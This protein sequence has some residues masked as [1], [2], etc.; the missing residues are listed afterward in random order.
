MRWNSSSFVFKAKDK[1][2]R[3]NLLISFVLSNAPK[4]CGRVGWNSRKNTYANIADVSSF[5]AVRQGKADNKSQRLLRVECL[6]KRACSSDARMIRCVP[7]DFHL[8]DRERERERERKRKKRNTTISSFHESYLY[9]FYLFRLFLLAS[10]EKNRRENS[11]RKS[12]KD[13]QKRH[14]TVFCFFTPCFSSTPHFWWLQNS[15][16][17]ER[18]LRVCTLW[19]YLSDTHEWH[20][21]TCPG[22]HEQPNG[23]HY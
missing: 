9:D 6:G 5:T 11:K 7:I 3:R 2:T 12:K 1:N 23:I 10:H 21:C 22:T 13:E 19:Q 18:S 4:C 8:F 15:F 14:G 20:R 16:G 17:C